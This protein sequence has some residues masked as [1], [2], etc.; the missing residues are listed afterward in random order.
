MTG[1]SVQ[2]R[3]T[4]L[5]TREREVDAHR[6]QIARLDGEIESLRG[7]VEALEAERAELKKERGLLFE[8][9]HQQEIAVAREEAHLSAAEAELNAH[10][11]RAKVASEERERLHEQL[12]DVEAALSLSD[13]R[14]GGEERAGSQKREEISNLQKSLAKSRAETAALRQQVLRPE[15]ERWP[16]NRG[17]WTPCGPT[18]TG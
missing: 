2:S 8:Q 11:R 15:R 7:E 18:A 5:L 10:V 13:G 1:G 12:S 17:A 6:A 16:P 9:L 3:M 14:E 4:S